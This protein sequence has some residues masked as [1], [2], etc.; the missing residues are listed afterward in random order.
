MKKC[1]RNEERRSKPTPAFSLYTIM[2]RRRYPGRREGD[3]PGYVDLY[4][5]LL[6]FILLL[7]IF[8]SV[9]DAHLTLDALSM[10]CKEINPIMNAA[11]GLGMKSFVAI[12]VFITG[13]GVGLLCMHKAFPRVKWIILAVLAGYVLLISY[14]VYLMQFR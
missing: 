3:P 8:L 7:I 11:L 13:L 9:A 5:P 1:R 2:G 10:G 4:H 6:F 12:K 14:H